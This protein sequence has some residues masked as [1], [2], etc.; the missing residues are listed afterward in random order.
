MRAL[1]TQNSDWSPDPSANKRTSG[2]DSN[3]THGRFR[4]LR[5]RVIHLPQDVFYNDVIEFWIPANTSN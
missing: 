1:Q 4:I 2:Y 5:K 3:H